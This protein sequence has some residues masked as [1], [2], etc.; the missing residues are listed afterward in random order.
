VTKASRV[1]SFRNFIP[2]TCF[3]PLLL[4]FRSAQMAFVLR[5][6]LRRVLRAAQSQARKGVATTWQTTIEELSQSERNLLNILAWLAPEPIPLSPLE[7]NIVD[8]ADARD[9]PAGPASWGPASRVGGGGR[10]Q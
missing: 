10:G 2:N 5:P 9:A 3:C 7:G 1:Q 6:L 8:D 4:R